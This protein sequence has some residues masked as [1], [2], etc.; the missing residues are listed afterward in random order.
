MGIN[1]N[2]PNILSGLRIVC[3]PL[4]LITVTLPLWLSGS[5]LISTTISLVLY[6]YIEISDMLDGYLARKHNIVSDLGKVLDPFGDSIARLSYFAAFLF[7]GIM[8]AFIFV[9]IWYRDMIVSFIRQ[10]VAKQGV[11]LAARFS[12]KFKAVIYAIAGIIG[13]IAIIQNNLKVIWFDADTF[14]VIVSVIFYI[15]GA[16]AVWTLVD[17]VRAYQLSKKV[18]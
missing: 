9:I 18:K 11:A 17:Y 16:V 4:F 14:S 3:A 10:L 6:A 13:M 7:Y 8:P 5:E 15:S 1:K 2:L 12:G